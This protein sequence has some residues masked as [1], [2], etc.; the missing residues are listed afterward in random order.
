MKPATVLLMLLLA[1][2][3]ALA[4]SALIGRGVSLTTELLRYEPNPAEPGDV[5]TVHLL[6]SNKGGNTAKN[7]QVELLD[8][9]PFYVTDPASRLKSLTA[10]PG[11]ESFLVKY[12][13]RVD[14]DADEGTAY[15]KVR[16][17]V[18]GGAS[19]QEELLP[20]D[21]RT[22]DAAIAIDD[23]TVTPPQVS[24]GGEAEINMTL[25]N[26][27]DSRLR[28][29]AIRLETSQAVGSETVQVPV[30]PLGG[31]FERRVSELAGGQSVI[32]RYRIIVQ[33][34]AASDVYR[35][36]VKVTFD[37]EAG[38]NLSASDQVSLVINAPTAL[39]AYVDAVELVPGQTA[40]DITLRV[41]NRGLSGIKF[42]TVE[43]G[44]D[45]SFE[46]RST[47][48]RLYVGNIDSDDYETETISL[49]ARK[50]PVRLPLHLEYLDALNRAGAKDIA[51]EVDMVSIMEDGKKPG[52]PLGV[53][54]VV[55][56]VGLIAWIVVRQVRRARRRQHL[57]A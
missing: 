54:A 17:G 9:H 57:K 39:E 50:N 30:A 40:G 27:A 33:P 42:L 43:V 48:A 8:N 18:L 20:L 10:I 44:T 14:K 16:T 56:L 22:L 11:Q 24:P 28:N 25:R 37:D 46:L 29:L 19:V 12:A 55:A 38:N 34:D 26:L 13:V 47:S 36:P 5:L 6:V 51:L 31:S 4:Q 1:A 21:V 23:I 2:A 32:V 7:V 3:P 35:L 52:S 41:V 53:A 49:R 15:L 45:E